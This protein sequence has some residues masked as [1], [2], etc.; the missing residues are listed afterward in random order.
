VSKNF[1]TA[2]DTIIPKTTIAKINSSKE[3]AGFITN[4][5]YIINDIDYN[6]YYIKYLLVI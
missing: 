4:P 5:Q 6:L 1:G 3:K 2:T